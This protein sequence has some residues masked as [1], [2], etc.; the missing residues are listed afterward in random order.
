M[1]GDPKPRT[2]CGLEPKGSEWKGGL[3]ETGWA[4]RNRPANRD[5]SQSPIVRVSEEGV[6]GTCD[7][8]LRT[9]SPEEGKRKET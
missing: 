1:V 5:S 8:N 7:R 9:Y 2:V 3:I 4:L 6:V